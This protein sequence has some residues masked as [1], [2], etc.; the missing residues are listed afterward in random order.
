M[1][2]T[3]YYLMKNCVKGLSAL[4][5][6]PID[7]TKVISINHSKRLFRI[8]DRDY[9]Y[10]MEIMYSNPR[11]TL[12]ITVVPIYQDT[13]FITLRYK[14]IEHIDEDI[15]EI[16][17]L[18]SIVEEYTADQHTKFMDFVKCRIEKKIDI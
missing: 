1:T 14:T 4:Q 2:T 3:L 9:K 11:V 15:R 10:T 8:F 5:V 16:Y 12:G 18:K 7:V 6:N 17:K 13:S